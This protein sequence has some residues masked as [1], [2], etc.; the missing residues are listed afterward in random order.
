MR[1][2]S[3]ILLYGVVAGLGFAVTARAGSFEDK[4]QVTV[5]GAEYML[6]GHIVKIEQDAYWI[7][8]TSGDVIRVGVTDGTHLI[9]PTRLNSMEAKMELKPGFVFRIGDCPFMLGDTVK[10]ETSDLV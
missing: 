3:V 2:I 8:K 1:Y 9:C 5:G 7:R 6:N 10:H 4:A